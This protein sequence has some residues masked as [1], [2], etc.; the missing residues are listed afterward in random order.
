MPLSPFY[1]LTLYTKAEYLNTSL[2]LSVRDLCIHSPD[3]SHEC[4]FLHNNI[5]V[6][7]N[8]HTCEYV[9]ILS[10]SKRENIAFMLKIICNLRISNIISFMFPTSLLDRNS[11]T[12]QYPFLRFLFIFSKEFNYLL[13]FWREVE[14]K[15]YVVKWGRRRNSNSNE[16]LI[17]KN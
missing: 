4:R 6:F 1:L 3:S 8:E 14:R 9:G 5:T 15:K 11:I 13:R 16:K 10:V 17:R 2:I 7:A 12:I